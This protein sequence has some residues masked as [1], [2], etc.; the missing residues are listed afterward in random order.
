MIDQYLSTRQKITLP[1]AYASLLIGCSTT[2]TPSITATSITATPTPIQTIVT[3][4]I[5]QPAIKPAQIIPLTMKDNKKPVIALVLGSGGARGYAHIGVIRMLEAYH[6]QPQ[7]VVGTS[8]GS[9]VGALYA[10]G[11]NADEL[12]KT[13]LAMKS[14]DVR[15]IS[16]S[17]QGF[18]NGKKIEDFVNLQVH[19]QPIERFP[20]HFAAVATELGTGKKVVF[21]QGDTGQAVRA[22]CS[23]PNMFTPFSIGD[24]SYVDGGLVSP[25]PV[26]T[27]RELGADIVIAVDILAQ[28][29][30]TA[31]SNMWGLFSQTINIMA[32]ELASKELA[33]ADIVIQPNLKKQHIFTLTSRDQSMIAGEEAALF[34]MDHIQYDIAHFSK[35][36]KSA[37]T[38]NTSQVLSNNR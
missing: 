35:N 1:L 23:I 30:D 28:P 9:F 7:I 21:T 31:T 38:N 3:T 19:Q 27:A 11:K 24:K 15:D 25:V 5:P 37:Q 33:Q 16:L 13:A 34:Q 2:P 4:A 17:K 36:A 14:S 12:E 32:K 22:S 26:E 29:E 6:I 8:A 20:I 10:S 18:F